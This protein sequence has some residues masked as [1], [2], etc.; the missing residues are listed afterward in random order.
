MAIC[1]FIADDHA[2]VRDGIVLLLEAQNDIR[3]VGSA[4]DGR[5]AIKLIQVK[6]PDIVLMD[7][8]MPKLNGI[9]A[10]AQICETC[11]GTR[12]IILSMHADVEHIYRALKAGA[13]GYL[14]K[15]SAGQEVIQAIRHVYAGNRYLSQRVSEKMVDD[16]V[17]HRR[18]RQKQPSLDRL[19]TREL[20][21]LQL[22]VEGRSSTEIA[23]VLFLS[24][25]T[26]DTYRSR[27]MYKLGIHDVPGL[28]KFAIQQ[29][30]TALD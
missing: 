25:K 23:K 4:A 27:I 2:V 14:L 1:V 16:Y 28:V 20:E 12:V 13:Y 10:T 19:S 18:E 6:Q 15:E 30:V 7:I 26:I 8:S 24:R 22:V 5:Q 17:F 29:G 3:V 21:T 9:E 11:R